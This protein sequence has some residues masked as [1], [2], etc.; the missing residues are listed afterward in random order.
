MFIS[1]LF[2]FLKLF[3][4]IISRSHHHATKYKLKNVLQYFIS[5][6]SVCLMCEL[7]CNWGPFSISYPSFSLWM[8]RSSSPTVLVLKWQK[9]KT[10][11][12]VL[13]NKLNSF[14]LFGWFVYFCGAQNYTT[15]KFVTFF[16][17]TKFFRNFEKRVE[18]FRKNFC[19]CCKISL[20]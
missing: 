12:L 2:Y 19:G 18:F 13:V 9:K 7:T 1:F 17:R 14:C 16:V 5:F 3:R 15:K 8:E 10:F 11:F 6:L 4:S 20:K